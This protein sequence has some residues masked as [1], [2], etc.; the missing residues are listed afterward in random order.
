M[1]TNYSL[2]SFSVSVY[3]RPHLSWPHC[4]EMGLIT[5]AIFFSD[6]SGQLTVNAT[7]T[8]SGSALPRAQPPAR[9]QTI[10]SHLR[11]PSVYCRAVPG[12]CCSPQGWFSPGCCYDEQSVRMDELVPY[13]LDEPFPL[14]VS[15]FSR[16]DAF[17]SLKRFS[18]LVMNERC[19]CICRFPDSRELTST[20]TPLSGLSF[21]CF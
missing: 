17:F 4:L 15:I 19:C 16:R 12:G 13:P 1:E 8:P 2:P 18:L 11:S 3:V 6:I 14:L 5:Y 7:V 9:V 21:L 10:K 20:R